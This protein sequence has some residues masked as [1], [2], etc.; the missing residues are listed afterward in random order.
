MQINS[1]DY[2]EKLHDRFKALTVRQPY[3]GMI[4]TPAYVDGDVTYG[5]KS[6]E[7]R[8]RTTN[9]RG[10]LLV[11]S[12]AVPQFPGM[13]SGVTLG[14]VELYD[15][16]PA[17]EFTDEDWANT[18]IPENEREPY[19]NG[20]GY[21]LRNPRPVVEMP[22]KGQLGIYNLVMPKGDMTFYPNVC[23]VDKKSWRMIQ[24]QIKD[25]QKKVQGHQP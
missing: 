13:M 17:S 22:V 24:K 1:K 2:D 19:R 4:V 14:M 11:C 23:H 5:I 6:I 7:V 3:A 10:E 25:G 20:Y 9:Y 18:G 21:M 16:K 12:S 15:V 8:N